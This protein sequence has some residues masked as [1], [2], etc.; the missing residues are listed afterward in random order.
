MDSVAA[1][2]RRSL[3]AGDGRLR[4]VVVMV[5]MMA[6]AMVEA[7][8]VGGGARRLSSASTQHAIVSTGV[9]CHRYVNSKQ[10][11]RSCADEDYAKAHA[12]S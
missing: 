10:Q 3:K 5:V 2:A 12:L 11:A 9:I 8:A 7:A 1:V 6:A 4:A